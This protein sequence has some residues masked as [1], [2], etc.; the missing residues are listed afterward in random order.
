MVEIYPVSPPGKR[1]VAQ[2]LN[3]DETSAQE[4]SVDLEDFFGRI[5][6]IYCE[7]TTATNF[8]LDASTDGS[9]WFNIKSWS[10]TTKVHEGFFNAFRYLKLRSDAAGS[11]GDTV[12]LIITAI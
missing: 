9:N 7:A 8:Y 11:S 1:I 5:V 4:V 6:E 2:L 3:A 10:S 12:T